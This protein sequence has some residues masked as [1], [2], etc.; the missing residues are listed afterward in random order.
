MEDFAD[1]LFPFAVA[2]GIEG[3]GLTTLHHR[4]RR[5]EYEVVRDGTRNPKI[6]GRS[7]LGRRQKHLK[8][9]TYGHRAGIKGIPAATPTAAA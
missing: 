5:G 6:T 3:V 8:P 9:A 2:A 7:I 1:R 4:V